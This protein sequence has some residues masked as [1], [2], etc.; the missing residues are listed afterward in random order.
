M[1]PFGGRYLIAIQQDACVSIENQFKILQ[2][3]GWHSFSHSIP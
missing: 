2:Q 3:N 1:K